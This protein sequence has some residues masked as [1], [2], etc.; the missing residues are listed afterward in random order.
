MQL[1]CFQI[2]S[3]GWFKWM[4]FSIVSLRI[5]IKFLCFTLTINT[6]IY[7]L[8]FGFIQINTT[9]N[10]SDFKNFPGIVMSAK[11]YRQISLSFSNMIFH[12]SHWCLQIRQFSPKKR[13]QL[14]NQSVS[15]WLQCESC[16][17]MSSNNLRYIKDSVL[18]LYLNFCIISD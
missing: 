3:P 5:E 11:N 12:L 9:S 4:S 13:N 1:F 18:T 7:F 2:Q 6:F 10:K 16:Q 15:I 8:L 17:T 14:D